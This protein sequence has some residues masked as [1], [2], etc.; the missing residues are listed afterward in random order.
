MIQPE[1]AQT[2]M[3]QS[4]TKIPAPVPATALDSAPKIPLPA[5]AE[6]PESAPPENQNAVRGAVIN[7]LTNAGQRMLS[8]MLGNRRM[9]D[10]G[11]RVGGQSNILRHGDRNVALR[12]CQEA[13]HRHR[14]RSSGKA[15]QAESGA[16]RSSAKCA[17]NSVPTNGGGRGRAE[18]DPVVNRMKEKFGAEI[19]TIIDYKD[20]R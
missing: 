1:I 11:Q 18:Q 9:A 15:G 10:R 19:R 7:A 17:A 4:E 2:E 5:M 20:K 8:A 6:Q 13:D 3:V 14:Q 16:G 12:R